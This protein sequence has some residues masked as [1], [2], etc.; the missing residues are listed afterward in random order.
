[1]KKPKKLQIVKK[2]KENTSLISE[3]KIILEFKE[4]VKSRP[5]VETIILKDEEL[6]EQED[7]K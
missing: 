4:E 3:S 2:I 5:R 6:K 7:I 1:M